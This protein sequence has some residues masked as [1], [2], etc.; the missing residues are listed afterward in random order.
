[1]RFDY[2]PG[3][4]TAPEWRSRRCNKRRTWYFLPAIRTLLVLVA[5]VSFAYADVKPTTAEM[6]A[7]KR[8][9]LAHVL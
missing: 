6:L 4:S 2:P 9:G 8:P 3:I 7:G 1:V 5:L